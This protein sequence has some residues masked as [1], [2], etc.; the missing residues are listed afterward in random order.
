M[1]APLVFEV[2]GHPAPQGSKAPTRYGGMREDNPRT[3]GWRETIALNVR[4]Q[5][6]PGHVPFDG[7]CLLVAF[8][9]MPSPART[10]RHR[11]W[12]AKKSR[13]SGDEDKLVRAACDGLT[14]AGVWS[15]DSRMVRHIAGT[16]YPGAPGFRSTP[17]CQLIVAP[18]LGDF[19]AD[20]VLAWR[21]DVLSNAS[22]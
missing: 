3:K 9:T 4:S 11:V 13:G 20:L 21:D 17:G 18:I 12:P 15:D 10:P 22:A 19:L 5:L 2:A 14:T 16:D 1:T 8:F 6:P 7:P